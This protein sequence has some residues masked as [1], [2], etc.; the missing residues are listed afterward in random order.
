[1]LR[2]LTQHHVNKNTR[3][4]LR[5]FLHLKSSPR[6]GVSKLWSA[7]QKQAAK[8]FCQWWKN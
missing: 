4:T 1:M 8:P 2:N 6:P 3:T 5:L 7:G